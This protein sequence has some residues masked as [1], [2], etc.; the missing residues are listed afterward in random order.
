MDAKAKIGVQA[1]QAV[2]SCFL[3]FIIRKLNKWS[4]IFYFFKE[5]TGWVTGSSSQILY[6]ASGGSEDWA[7]G[8]AKIKYSYCLELRPGQDETTITSG[9][10]NGF[11][12]PESK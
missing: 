11:T 6:V 4:I 12:L 8:T 1:L 10:G 7:Y 5:E 2:Y 3:F 9:N